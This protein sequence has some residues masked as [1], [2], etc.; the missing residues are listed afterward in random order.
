MCSSEYLWF[1]PFVNSFPMNLST[2]FSFCSLFMFHLYL[3]RTFSLSCTPEFFVISSL[4]CLVFPLWACSSSWIRSWW[5]TRLVRR[6]VQPGGFLRKKLILRNIQFLG[7]SKSFWEGWIKK[8]V[9]INLLSILHLIVS[10]AVHGFRICCIYSPQLKMA[11]Q[12]DRIQRTICLPFE[13]VYKSEKIKRE[14]IPHPLIDNWTRKL[15]EE[16][17][18]L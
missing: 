1:S 13:C 18:Y 4:P 14:V 16:W 8:K 3:P 2:A 10:L 6:S 11:S 17:L 7:G 9:Q 15:Y 12:V 5:K